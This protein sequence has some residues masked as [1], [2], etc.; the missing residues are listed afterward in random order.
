MARLEDA[1]T[2]ALVLDLPRFEANC[3]RMVERLHARGTRLRPHVK[4]LKA[5]QAARIALDPAHGGIAVSTLTEAEYFAA[6]GF[7][8][9][10]IVPTQSPMHIIEGIPA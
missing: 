2:P 4:T 9:T 8:L 7:T 5:V 1:A 10:R 3:R 6:A